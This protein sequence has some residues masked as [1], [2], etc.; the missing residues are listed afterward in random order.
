MTSEEINRYKGVSLRVQTSK[1]QGGVVY[2][3]Y[4]DPLRGG[5]QTTKAAGTTREEILKTLDEVAQLVSECP[6]DALRDPLT[7][8][9]VVAQEWF[10]SVTA[11]ERLAPATLDNKA[12][13]YD[14]HLRERLGPRAIHDIDHGLLRLLMRRLAAEGVGANARSKTQTLLKDVFQ[15]AKKV[16]Y[17]SVDPTRNLEPITIPK[18]NN[19]DDYLTVD[20]VKSLLDREALVSLERQKEVRR[21]TYYHVHLRFLVETGCRPGEMLAIRDPD[22]YFSETPGQSFVWIRHSRYGER[23]KSTKTAAGDRKIP[24]SDALADEL[25]AH[26]GRRYEYRH[27]SDERAL[28]HGGTAAAP[29]NP[30]GF[31][32]TSPWGRPLN[33]AQFRTV[34]RKV[35]S[36]AGLDVRGLD[37]KPIVPHPYTMRRTFLTHLTEAG[38]PQSAMMA[39]AGHRDF[40]ATQVYLGSTEAARREALGG[41]W[42]RL[43]LDVASTRERE[44]QRS[45]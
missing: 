33:L 19:K 20:E 18:P 40:R 5:K 17:I 37:D 1:T 28:A 8:F 12:A 35:C 38:A 9:G 29:P 7:L 16:G 4:R 43:E 26:L 6:P 15:W 11:S 10:D 2:V 36:E 31:V 25:R 21:A 45:D 14:A 13:F 32:F 41:L 42:S 44:S 22:L 30:R 24:I 27:A 23:L 34:M 3:C 39:L